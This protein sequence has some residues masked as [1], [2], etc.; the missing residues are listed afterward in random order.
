[1]RRGRSP[2]TEYFGETEAAAMQLAGKD[3]YKNQAA[4]MYKW[5]AVAAC[6]RVVFPDVITGLYTPDEMGADVTE[7]GEL[8]P[9][10]K[11][12]LRAIPPTTP[13]EPTEGEQVNADQRLADIS[14]IK[15]VCKELMAA[16]DDVPW[17]T[18]K[19]LA[20][21]AA[22]LFGHDVVSNDDLT[23]EE[24]GFLLEDLKERLDSLR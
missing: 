8:L 6:A 17:M 1:M 13:V 14:E 7:D 20:D 2:H 15:T 19:I 22:Q 12:N 10:V 18:R 4:T 5:R 23:D 21:Y 16:G 11:D 3:N 9:P 24:V